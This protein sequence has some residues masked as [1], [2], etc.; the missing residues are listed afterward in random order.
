MRPWRVGNGGL[1]PFIKCWWY[2]HIFI[3]FSHLWLDCFFGRNWFP[4]CVC[5]IEWIYM[6]N[7]NRQDIDMRATCFTTRLLTNCELGRGR[8]SESWIIVFAPGSLSSGNHI[9]QFKT[10][11]AQV[12]FSLLLL[13]PQDLLMVY[14]WWIFNML[15]VKDSDKSQL[16]AQQ[17]N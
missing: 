1:K 13:R 14:K 8:M 10:A 7:K 6:I 12:T 9:L 2:F 16:F 3:G 17:G 11:W 5:A 4:V 15:A